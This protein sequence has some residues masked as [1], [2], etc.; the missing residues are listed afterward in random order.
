MQTQLKNFWDKGFVQTDINTDLGWLSID[1]DYSIR[2]TD[3]DIDLNIT[4]VQDSRDGG[5]DLEGLFDE[6]MLATH[7]LECLGVA[8]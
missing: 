2:I 8:N 7:L 6:D 5:A 1:I 3:G 4:K